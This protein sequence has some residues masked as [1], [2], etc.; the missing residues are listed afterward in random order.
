[1]LQFLNISRTANEKVCIINAQTYKE[2]VTIQNMS[3]YM[4][5]FT[6]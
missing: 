3:K 4:E 2:A 1:M 5:L 6:I